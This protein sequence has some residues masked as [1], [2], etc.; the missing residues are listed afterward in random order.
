LRRE[1]RPYFLK[2]AYLKF[3]HVYARHFLRPQF[4]YLGDGYTV[5]QP[6]NIEIFGAPIRLGRYAYIM[7]TSD[8]K[9]RLT[10]WPEDKSK[11][12]IEIGNYCLICPGV[13][14][15]SADNIRIGDNTMMAS[16][17]YITD[18]DWHGIYN[19]IWTLG[20]TAPVSIGENVW[21][22]DSAIICKGVNIGDNSV[23]GAGSVVIRSI[24]PNTVAAGNP[25]RVVKELD[26]SQSFAMR[27]EWFANP[28]QL[29]KEIEAMD[30]ENLKGNT[31][32]HWL[33]TLFFPRRTD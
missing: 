6:W 32:L 25:A 10:V 29:A 17:A 27:S 9:I 8:K 11:G 16:H 14:I 2:K 31:V 18:S 3:Q 7:S 26:P 28:S 22:G 12:G 20:P 19:R 30:R 23:I 1:H 15:S 21:I 33:R 4:D 24:P 5:T 13:R